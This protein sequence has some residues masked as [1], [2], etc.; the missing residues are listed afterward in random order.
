MPRL[1]PFVLL[2]LLVG[3]SSAW[4]QLEAEQPGLE[5]TPA[6]FDIPVTAGEEATAEV[7]VRNT[8]DQFVPVKASLSNFEASDEFGRA[9]FYED[10]RA[11]YNAKSWFALSEAD[12][13]FDPGEEKKVTIAITPPNNAEPGSHFAS[14]IFTA[15]S[16]P[17]QPTGETV[18]VE[19]QV[20]VLFFLTVSGE[21]VSEAQITDLRL[22]TIHLG[23]KMPVGV[24]VEN[25]GNVHGKA[26]GTIK[27]RNWTGQEVATLPLET[28]IVV[29]GRGRVYRA[30]WEP[31]WPIGRYSAEATIH[32][33]GETLLA[34]DEF[35]AIP[36]SWILVGLAAIIV[37]AL[38]RKTRGRWSLAWAFFRG[39]FDTLPEDRIEEESPHPPRRLTEERKPLYDGGAR[40]KQ[41]NGSK[42]KK[43][44][45]RS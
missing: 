20:A 25:R 35:W 8:S 18:A 36:L 24:R 29:P 39:K 26:E 31:R 7:T 3:L 34:S 41:R 5:V 37:G 1:L 23:G 4:A 11:P 33:K 17:A 30:I 15:L 32:F 10:D 43:R 2:F 13:I 6:L 38:Y 21:I 16:P 14:V 9:F 12:F 42:R 45:R 22:P 44:A 19:A 28:G 27:L 40:R